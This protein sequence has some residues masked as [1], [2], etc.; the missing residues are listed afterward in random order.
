MK[1]KKIIAVLLAGSIMLSMAACGGGS[2]GSSATKENAQSDSSAG[3]ADTGT[4]GGELDYTFGAD[5]TFHSDEPVTYSMMYSDHENY[6]YQENWRLW[7]AIAEKTNVTFDLNIIARTDYEDKKS[8]LVNSGDAAYIIPKTYDEGKYVAGGQV[9][10]ISDWVQ[11][12]PNFMKAVEDWN[13][14]DDLKQKYQSDGKYYVLPGMWETGGGGYGYII[15]KD[16]FEAAG[17]NVAEL[18]KTWT[19]EAFY[20][21]CKKVKDFTGSAYV[22][23]EASKGDCLLNL[24]AVPYGANGGWGMGGGLG[25]DFDTNTFY[26]SDTTEN[27]KDWLAMLNHMVTDGILDPESFS[28]EDDAAKAKFFTGQTAVICGNYQNL[29]DFSTQMQDA[30]AQLYMALVPGGN[31]GLLQMENSRLEN[32]IMISRNALDELG[33]EGFIKM[34]RFVDWLWYSEEGHILSQWGVEGETYTLDA[35]GNFVLDS[36][37]TY[38][39]LNPD[40]EKMLNADY[41]FAGGVFAYGG[42]ARL[43]NSRMTTD[44]ERDYNSR[45][46]EHREVRPIVPP[47]MA[48]ADESEELAIVQTP[49]IDSTKVWIQKFVTGQSDIG[50]QWDTF[51][52]EI[53]GL[54]VENYVNTVNEIFE[55]NKEVLGYK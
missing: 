26:F 48:N 40:A 27:A 28:Q 52:S 5:V 34:L 18:E 42:S 17:V 47:Y 4:A 25:F 1:A 11:Y 46:Q 41:G 20:E 12:M 10:A 7:S 24:T 21:A 8:V 30:D 55:K 32:G 6:P 39:G 33:E 37:I 2:D 44:G 54:G 3:T 43:Y 23:S 9:V 36:N 15:R 16:I 49:I 45:I 50:T 51:V 13:M 19:Y 38:N 29:N 14:E 22:I 53:N 35:Q 31:K